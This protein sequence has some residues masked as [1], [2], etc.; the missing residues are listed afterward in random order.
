MSPKDDL[1]TPPAFLTNCVIRAC[2]TNCLDMPWWAWPAGGSSY[3]WSSL[4]FGK[5][6]TL[7]LLSLS[8]MVCSC[9]PSLSVDAST[10]AP[11][12]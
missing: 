8:A 9:V 5:D 4:F 3:Y 2:L 1:S 12:R 6:Y 10:V 7:S 11:P